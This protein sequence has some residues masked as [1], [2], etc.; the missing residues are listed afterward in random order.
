MCVHERCLGLNPKTQVIF[1]ELIPTLE[2]GHGMGLLSYT[3][4]GSI[5]TPSTFDCYPRA[6]EDF[7]L[8]RGKSPGIRAWGPWNFK[9]MKIGGGRDMCRER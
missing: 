9:Q 1:R 3:T 5:L 6:P 7:L 4:K 8:G 2:R